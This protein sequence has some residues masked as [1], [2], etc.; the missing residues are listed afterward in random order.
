MLLRN[1][2]QVNC[3][4]TTRQ[5]CRNAFDKLTGTTAYS[6]L[7]RRRCQRSRLYS[8][9]VVIHRRHGVVLLVVFLSQNKCAL[10]S[11]YKP[12]GYNCCAPEDAIWE[13]TADRRP[14]KG[15]VGS[16]FLAW[17]RNGRASDLRS[18]G[19]SSIPGRARLR[20]ESGQVVHT[21]L[22]RRRHSSLVYRV[23]KLGTF[24]F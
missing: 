4:T 5:A 9:W 3:S 2:V 24:T 6:P 11:Y 19:R 23:V 22:P 1:E 14:L 20:N 10:V 18:R 7:K 8:H 21:Q 16:T 12:D 17:W 13:T 15:A